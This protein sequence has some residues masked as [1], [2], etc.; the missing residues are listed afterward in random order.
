MVE[1]F[2]KEHKASGGLEGVTRTPPPP[3]PNR[4]GKLFVGYIFKYKIS[5]W[6]NGNILKVI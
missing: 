6:L 3:P 2:M 4:S 5:I 1:K